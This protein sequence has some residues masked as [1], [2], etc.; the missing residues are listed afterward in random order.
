VNSKLAQ[1]ALGMVAGGVGAD[2]QRLGDGGV[3]SALGQQRS[4]LE[5]S[6][7]KSVS[8]L[9]VGNSAT[10]CCAVA[11]ASASLFLKLPAKLPHLTQG[12]AELAEQ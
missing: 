5:L 1:D 11:T 10:S 8:V 12:F 7:S 2:V 9:E 4:Y 6:P 3:R